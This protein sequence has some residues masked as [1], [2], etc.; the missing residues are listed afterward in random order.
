VGGN[1]G[2]DRMEKTSAAKIIGYI[3]ITLIALML[4]IKI[5]IPLLG[6]LVNFIWSIAGLFSWV[7]KV[8]FFLILLVALIVGIIMLISWLVREF[9]S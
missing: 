4:I 8:V 9:S 5:G 6:L 7:V 2:G 3:V 1:Q